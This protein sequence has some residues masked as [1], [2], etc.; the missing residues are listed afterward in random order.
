MIFM[1]LSRLQYASED[2]P[3]SCSLFLSPGIFSQRDAVVIFLAGRCCY[4]SRGLWVL[5]KKC[6]PFA[7]RQCVCICG[8]SDVRY[9][10]LV[11][12]F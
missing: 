9:H 7:T 10:D 1:P 4:S 11:K 8:A 3:F 5:T 6:Q 12:R 2:M